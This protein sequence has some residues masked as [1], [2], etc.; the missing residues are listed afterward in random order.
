MKESIKALLKQELLGAVTNHNTAV[1]IA[2]LEAVLAKVQEEAIDEAKLGGCDIDGDIV[3][4][5]FDIDYSEYPEDEEEDE[6]IRQMLR[7]QGLL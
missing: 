2:E 4:D 7:K 3:I 1:T 5:L 6:E